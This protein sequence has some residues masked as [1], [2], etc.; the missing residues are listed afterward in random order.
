[1]ENL[2][3][4]LGELFSAI[5]RSDV[6]QV[7]RLLSARVS[8][9]QCNADGKTALMVAS[10]I[11]NPTIIQMLCDAAATHKP[12]ER[13]FLET[14]ITAAP[15]HAATGSTLLSP[16]LDSYPPAAVLANAQQPSSSD[17][18]A[19]L[20]QPRPQ[21]PLPD[22]ASTLSVLTDRT[23]IDSVLTSTPA[24]L[25]PALSPVSPG[26]VV[27]TSAAAA[28]KIPASKTVAEGLMN[29]ATKG[30]RSLQGKPPAEPSLS[31][32]QPV[33]QPV[34]QSVHNPLHK[35]VSPPV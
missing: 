4:Q 6:H 11:G 17:Y 35:P 21:L 24:L 25:Q 18:S 8:P 32:N 26:R 19:I 13:I 1:M 5:Q 31:V 15:H 34:R 23:L 29:L 27:E 3:T 33:R 28:S 7:R 12:P 22:Y 10:S 14:G 2:T 16:A 20:S 30:L 9:N